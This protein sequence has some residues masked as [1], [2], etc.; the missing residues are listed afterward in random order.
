MIMNAKGA[1]ADAVKVQLFRADHFPNTERARKVLYEFPR[2][3]FGW[4]VRYAHSAGLK[5]GASAF[6]DDAVRLCSD[7]GADF[8]KL[9]TREQPN[10]AL[11]TFCQ[12]HFHRT[13]IRS[14]VWPMQ[15]TVERWPRE[16]TLGCISEYPADD[17]TAWHQVHS[18][19]LNIPAP[20]GWSSHTVGWFDCLTAFMRG[21]QV[22]EKHIYLM[23]DDP[24]SGWSLSVQNFGSM[25]KTIRAY[26]YATARGWQ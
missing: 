1:H 14:V 11:R 12:E 7:T 8:V 24:E 26:E 16:I 13:V 22:I 9:A 3:E 2:N 21:A 6:D 10:V 25:I 19:F 15:E 20:R 5:V 17:R 4:F 18:L 23:E